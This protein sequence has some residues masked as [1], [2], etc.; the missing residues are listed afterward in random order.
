MTAAAQQ[1]AEA[2]TA[3]LPGIAGIV[4]GRPVLG[5]NDS[6]A[7]APPAPGPATCR[8]CPRSIE[9]DHYFLYTDVWRWRAPGPSMYQPDWDCAPGHQHEPEPQHEL[10]PGA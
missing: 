3:S 6:L 7:V 1:Q 9:A 4:A 2:L 5:Y 8:W 10:E